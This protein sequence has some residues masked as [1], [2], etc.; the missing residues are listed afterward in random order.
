MAQRTKIMLVTDPMEGWLPVDVHCA[1]TVAEA[2][3]LLLIGP[4][5]SPGPAMNI[6]LKAHAC[7][8]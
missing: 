5:A 1:I 2:A 6:V 4:F 7:I 3:L 8:I